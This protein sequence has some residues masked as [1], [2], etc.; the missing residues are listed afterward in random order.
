MTM[1]DLFSGLGGASRA[2][3]ERGW[4]VVRVDIEPRFRPSVVADARNVSFHDFRPDL[5]WASPV[6]TEFA[7]ESMPWCRTGKPPSL[8]LVRAAIRVRDEVRPRWWIIEN[9]RGAMRWLEPLLGRPTMRIGAAYLWG[10]FP[11]PLGC[12]EPKPGKERIGPCPD[13][14]AL[15]SLIP[16][17]TSLAIA[18]ACERAAEA[19]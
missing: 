16:H 4:R 8:D 17:E 6:C 2:M 14:P 12:R 11:L 13:R 15:R 9:V 10:E 7:R 3:S 19:A 5:F 18:Q 1:L